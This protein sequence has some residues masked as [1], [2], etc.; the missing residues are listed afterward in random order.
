MKI[1][2]LAALLLAATVFMPAASAEYFDQ[3]WDRFG[4][5]VRKSTV[6]GYT[7][8]VMALFK[9]Q[10]GGSMDLVGIGCDGLANPVAK[11]TVHK[12]IESAKP[13]PAP[14]PV[15]PFVWMAVAYQDGEWNGSSGPYPTSKVQENVRIA[16]GLQK[17]TYENQIEDCILRFDLRRYPQGKE[18]IKTVS[19]L[20]IGSDGKIT[21]IAISAPDPASQ[22]FVYGLLSRSHP[23]PALPKQYQKSPNFKVVIE[24]VNNDGN[25]HHN[26]TVTHIP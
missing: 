15:E 5:R 17:K 12:L 3:F 7:G 22:K 14:S 20:K 10:P 8:S 26:A 24:W 23:Y 21:G 2:S 11:S 6:P 9:V 16:T 4:D 1:K 25:G 13:L 18:I 19:T